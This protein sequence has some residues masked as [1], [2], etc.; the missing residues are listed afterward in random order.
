MTKLLDKKNVHIGDEKDNFW[1]QRRR[2]EEAH[3]EQ[4]KRDKENIPQLIELHKE[5][6]KLCDKKLKDVV[7]IDI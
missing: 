4:L 3:I 6:I 7:K 5:I 2:V 1:F